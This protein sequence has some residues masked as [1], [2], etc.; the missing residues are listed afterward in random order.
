MSQHHWNQKHE[1]SNNSLSVT[2]RNWPK[3]KSSQTA[4]V[5]VCKYL[6]SPLMPRFFSKEQE[7]IALKSFHIASPLKEKVKKQQQPRK[8]GG[9]QV[10]EPRLY[11]LKSSAN[12]R[13]P[14]W[15]PWSMIEWYS[16]KMVLSSR[17]QDLKRSHRSWILLWCVRSTQQ[18]PKNVAGKEY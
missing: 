10:L 18:Y 2:S 8:Q 4:I 11:V 12:Q 6:L 13:T 3:H 17:V 5:N 7:F 16:L 14:L 15:N 1:D 9:Q